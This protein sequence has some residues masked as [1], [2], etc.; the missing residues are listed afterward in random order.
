MPV[1]ISSL[2]IRKYD[3]HTQLLIESIGSVRY[4]STGTRYGIVVQGWRA[5][6]QLTKLK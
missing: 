5:V 4:A 6:R 1:A 3:R 2:Q